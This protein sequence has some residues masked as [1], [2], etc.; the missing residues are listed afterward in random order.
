VRADARRRARTYDHTC[1]AAE[2]LR[3]AAFPFPAEMFAIASFVVK[4]LATLQ[5]QSVNIADFRRQAR[6]IATAVRR[7]AFIPFRT[8][9]V[10]LAGFQLQ[11]L[12]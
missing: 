2:F 4:Q 1:F 5:R 9:S 3:A 7:T 12:R 10:C 11:L 6:T 8:Q